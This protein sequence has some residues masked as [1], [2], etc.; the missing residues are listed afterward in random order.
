[1]A[2]AFSTLNIAWPN[3]SQLSTVLGQVETIKYV[4]Q[5]SGKGILRVTTAEARH[6]PELIESYSAAIAQFL[7]G[8][9]GTWSFLATPQFDLACVFVTTTKQAKII[10]AN[11]V[12]IFR[13]T[14]DRELE[15]QVY[16]DR[17][18]ILDT[19]APVHLKPHPSED[20]AQVEEPA[21][22][23]A[24]AKGDKIIALVDMARAGELGDSFELGIDEL[25]IEEINLLINLLND[26]N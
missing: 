23:T 25:S 26:L 10:V 21:P 7:D 3:S 18:H 8:K 15:F 22:L 9:T 11:G 19:D 1:M 12:T 13:V 2:I 4:S 5:G 6:I 17:F 16:K 20:Q 14:G 24:P